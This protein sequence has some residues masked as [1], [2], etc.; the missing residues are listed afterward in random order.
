MK[1]S[2]EKQSDG[3]YIV[4]NTD[5]EHCTLIGT[6]NSVKETKEDFF[7]SVEEVRGDYIER[8]EAVP[9]ELSTDVE[10]YFDIS[11]L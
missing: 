4:Y 6:G 2:I 10:F 1:V 8:G 11:T 5:G 7:N 3:T 9:A